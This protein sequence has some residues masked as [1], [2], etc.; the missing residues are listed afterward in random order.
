MKRFEIV[1]IVLIVLGFILNISGVA[2]GALVISLSIFTL[3]AFYFLCSYFLFSNIGLRDAFKSSTF[4][5]LSILRIIG[6][7]FCG[8][9]LGLGLLGLLFKWQFWPGASFMLL[10]A[11]VNISVI[12][13]ISI[14][15]FTKQKSIFYKNLL[16]RAV[17]MFV[18][19][20]VAFFLPS[21]IIAEL[22]YRQHPQ[23]LEALRAL[24]EDPNNE[25]LKKKEIEEWEKIK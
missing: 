2:G 4:K 10:V 25:E 21:I 15:K 11:L 22:K 18:L 6:A 20:I 24:Q 1:L 23:Y 8:A 17:V 7:F 9:F 16:K 19:G 3:S 14:I 5:S 12:L 13:I